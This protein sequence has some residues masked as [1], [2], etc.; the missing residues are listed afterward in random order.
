MAGSFGMIAA[1]DGTPVRVAVFAPERPA[2]TRRICVLLQGHS[3]FI[4]KYV[5]VI[6]ELN[7]RGFTVAT[8]D[9]RGQGGSKRL[10]A[11]SLVGHVRDFSGYQD[12]LTSFLYHTVRP[13]TAGP[14]LVLA[15]SMG[16][17][18]A[19][20][21]LHDRPELFSAAVL[22]APML[23][24]S[25]RGYPEPLTRAVTAWQMQL[26]HSGRATWGLKKH[27]PLT[28]RFQR[29]LCTSDEARFLRTKNI[30]RA[31]PDLRIQGPSWGW[32]DAAYRSMAVTATPGF[33]EAIAAPVL[34]FGAG[35]DRIVKT[36]VNRAFAKR[37]PRGRYVEI[38]DSEHEILMERDSIRARFWQEFDGFVNQS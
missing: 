26:G 25:T 15:H 17:H 29:Q 11:D 13:L 3:E 35:K 32:I 22:C 36:D 16:A 5:E 7:A 21:A 4:E 14:V 2:K 31:H 23:A 18:I 30:L 12:D 1:E 28:V 9:W 6:G 37:L 38:E 34:L 20:R 24:I 19:L 10:L 8:L 33:A 27:D